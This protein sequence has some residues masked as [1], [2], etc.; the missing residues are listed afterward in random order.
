[1]KTTLIS[2]IVPIYNVERYLGKCIESICKQSYPNLEIILVDD[3]STDQS[4][5]LCD[6]YALKDNRIRVI[7][8][9]NEGL[10]EARNVGINAALGAWY[11]FV[12]SDDY[13]DLNTAES[14]LKAAT[15]ESCDIAV[16]NMLRV[17]ED[18]KIRPFYRPSTELRVLDGE[19][20]FET[21]RQPSVCN[22]LFRA[23][24]FENV[25]FPR[26]KFYED[27]FIYHVLAF[28][29]KRIVLTGKDGY[30]YLS[31]EESILGQPQYTDKYFDFIE[32]VYERAV[33]L[34]RYNI[35]TYGE[36]ACLSLY[37][38]VANGEK[39]IPKTSQNVECFHKMWKWYHFSYKKMMLSSNITFK[40]KLRLFL[41]KYTP[42]FHCKLY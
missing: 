5:L 36:E 30:Y 16:C 26:G 35:T 21:L 9:Q 20:R 28:K 23:E 14:L 3:G 6:S 33:Y 40:Q 12:D 2:V 42:R 11:L 7:H 37:V 19:Q 22:K 29:A 24:L 31:R 8:K 41:L 38:A 34:Y 25:R 18:S 32:A 1:M 27:T 13:L 39:Y 17:Y 4:G 10:S 15:D